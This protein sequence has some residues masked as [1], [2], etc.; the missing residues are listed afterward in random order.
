VEIYAIST[1]AERCFLFEAL[2][3]IA[4]KK[5]PIWDR[6]P[7]GED[8]DLRFHDDFEGKANEYT[9]DDVITPEDCRRV[10]LQPNPAYEHD[11]LD[12]GK[13][14]FYELDW[15]DDYEAGR[16][17]ADPREINPFSDEDVSHA[18]ELKNRYED[19]LQE[20]DIFLME[21]KLSLGLK[22]LR[23]EIPAFVKFCRDP[24]AKINFSHPDNYEQRVHT[25]APAHI[26]QFNNIDWYNAIINHSESEYFDVCV[27]TPALL[28]EFPIGDAEIV[29][30]YAVGYVL[31]VEPQKPSVLPPKRH[32]RPSFPWPEM[33]IELGRRAERGELPAKQ[34][35]LIAEMMDWCQRK[36]G[37]RPS[38]SAIQSHLPPNIAKK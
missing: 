35:A 26:F 5:A 36:W 11:V 32:G 27:D 3:W 25:S 21:A 10:G 17:K 13:V 23:G 20:L 15:L 18:R 19:W 38:R 2:L 14:S 34:E 31:I 8:T 9:G 22:L 1:L 4:F 6:F 12:E 33:Y 24:D 37:R 16:S 29:K 28:R 7:V 30:A